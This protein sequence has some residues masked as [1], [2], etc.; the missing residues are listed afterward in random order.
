MHPRTPAHAHSDT[1][2]DLNIGEAGSRRS[3]YTS[4]RTSCVAEPS[5]GGERGLYRRSDPP[6]SNRPWHASPSEQSLSGAHGGEGVL[7][8][9]LDQVRVTVSRRRAHRGWLALGL[10]A[11]VFV[12]ANHLLVR[13]H[14]VGVWDAEHQFF[15]FFTLVADHARAGR[16]VSWDPWSNGGLPISG[17]PQ[18]GVFSPVTVGLAL[19]TGGGSRGFITYWLLTWWAGGAGMFV[20]SRHLRAPRWASIVLALGFLFC[21]VYTANAEHISWVVGFSF[22]PWIIWRI[23]VACQTGRRVP[24][25]QAG[26]LWGLSALAGYPGLVIIT[27][28]FTGVWLLG[29]SMLRPGGRGGAG[30]RRGACRPTRASVGCGDPWVIWC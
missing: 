30:R 3:F 26:A 5:P 19:L 10:P 16:L 14:A 22:L 23:D 27:A 13:G 17:E 15:P 7:A 8:V 18:V 21:G 9:S 20:L 28:M 6:P 1:G 11:L 2:L 29:R 24:A 4:R 25:V 12:L